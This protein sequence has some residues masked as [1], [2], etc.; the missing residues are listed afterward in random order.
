MLLVSYLRLQASPFSPRNVCRVSGWPR[1]SRAFSTNSANRLGKLKYPDPPSSHH[2]DLASF[3]SYAQKT[4]LNAKSTVYVGTHY[5]YQ[6]AESLSRYGFALRRIGGASDH[7]TD[8][9][10]TWTLP[11][12]SSPIS[13]RVLVQCKA[14]SQGVGPRHVRE[15]EGAFVGAPVGWRGTGVLGVLV[16]EWSATRGVRDSLTRSR[17]PMVFIRCSNKGLVS[18]MLWNGPARELGLDEYG[19]SVK[20]GGSGECVLM[21]GGRTIPLLVR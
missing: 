21:H 16:N 9:V 1:A 10:G 8:L 2:S 15:L 20:H 11:C 19:I 3:V 18:Q 7:G 12:G 6:V 13:M 17:W 14:G 5:E 4:G